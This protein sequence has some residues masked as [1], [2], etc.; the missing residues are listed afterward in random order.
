[1]L[2]ALAITEAAVVVVVMTKEVVAATTRQLNNILPVLEEHLPIATAPHLM[3]R[4]RP[5]HKERLAIGVAATAA[6]E[7]RLM[8]PTL[9]H[10]PTRETLH[11]ATTNH[12][13]LPQL[14]MIATR[15]HFLTLRVDTLFRIMV[16]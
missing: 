11:T 5:I 9:T 7:R 3:H 10:H 14:P 15:S 13:P 2:V 1:M 8:N 4:L 16:E 12:L 6:A